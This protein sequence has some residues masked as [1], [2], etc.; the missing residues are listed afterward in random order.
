MSAEVAVYRH[1][2]RGVAYPLSQLASLD[3]S[4]AWDES[5]R[6]IRTCQVCKRVFL[7]AGAAYACEL[8]PHRF[9]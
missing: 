5:T 3:V 6:S 2:E 9:T 8:S 7:H 4:K 1:A